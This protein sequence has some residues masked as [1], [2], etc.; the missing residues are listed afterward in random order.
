MD[1][2]L[3]A[4]GLQREVVL[5]VPHFLFALD[6]VRRTDLVAMLPSRLVHQAEGLRVVE[7]PLPVAGYQIAMLWHEA[8]HRDPAQ[9]WLREQMVASLAD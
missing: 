5:L 6:T 2:A 4:L 8:V 1:L 3:Q 7:P 9:V